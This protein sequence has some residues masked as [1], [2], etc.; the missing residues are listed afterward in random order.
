MARTTN[1]IETFFKSNCFYNWYQGH[2]LLYPQ[3]FLG[4]FLRADK[5]RLERNLND[6]IQKFQLRN[7]LDSP[8]FIYDMNLFHRTTDYGVSH[9]PIFV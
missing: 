1:S 2:N 9:V 3:V 4:G 5:K 8:Q 7:W 6:L